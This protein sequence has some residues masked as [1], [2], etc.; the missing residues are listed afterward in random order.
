ML[1][2]RETPNDWVQVFC[3]L[4]IKSGDTSPKLVALVITNP[5]RTFAVRAINPEVKTRLEDNIHLDEIVINKIMGII[6]L[7]YCMTSI[8]DNCLNH[9]I[10]N[11]N[12]N[13]DV[14][15]LTN[16]F[17]SFA[18]RATASKPQF[19]LAHISC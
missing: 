8:S 13:P 19:C 14:V 10:A 16:D 3:G 17:V 11:I 9:L 12:S 6:K 18:D 7:L 1:V 2:P 5:G 4:S 15:R